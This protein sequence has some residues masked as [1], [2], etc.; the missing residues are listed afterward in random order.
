MRINLD[1]ALIPE[2]RGPGRA[3]GRPAWGHSACR[4]GESHVH[5]C[6]PAPNRPGF[7]PH[8]SPGCCHEGMWGSEVT[9]PTPWVGGGQIGPEPGFRSKEAVRLKKAGVQHLGVPRVAHAP[10]AAR[11]RHSC[12]CSRNALRPSL[13]PSASLTQAWGSLVAPW[14]LQT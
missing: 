11:G 9:L 10:F 13:H 7:D 12:G 2:L 14:S 3:V 8:H 5:H 6:L 4:R 1:L